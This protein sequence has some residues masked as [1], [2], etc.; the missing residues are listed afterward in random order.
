[1]FH[2]CKFDRDGRSLNLTGTYL[3]SS[4]ATSRPKV[5]IIYLLFTQANQHNIFSL[6]DQY[7]V[8]W[9]RQF[10]KISSDKA[11]TQAGE[12]STIEVNSKGFLPL[13]AYIEGCRWSIVV[14]QIPEYVFICLS[15]VTTS[16][17]AAGVTTWLSL[18]K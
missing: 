4:D 14:Y 2:T 9:K 16:G 8:L 12:L 11:M 15:K 5:I 1:M 13:G 18:F 3:A 6:M 7:N 10:M 17:T